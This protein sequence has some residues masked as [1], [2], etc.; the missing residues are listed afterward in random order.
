MRKVALKKCASGRPEDP[1]NTA[2]MLTCM[3]T[4]PEGFI[5]L[6]SNDNKSSTCLKKSKLAAQWAYASNACK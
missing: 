1:A 3:S 4:K 6:L 2:Q 5:V